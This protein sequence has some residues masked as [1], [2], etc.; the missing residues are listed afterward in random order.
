MKYCPNCGSGLNDN[1]DFCQQCGFKIRKKGSQHSGRKRRNIGSMNTQT[2]VLSAL[3]CVLI[4]GCV[5]VGI[6]LFS[7]MKGQKY[8]DQLSAANELLKSKEYQQAADTYEELTK[9][10]PESKDAYKGMA[11]AYS[12]LADQTK[13]EETAVKFR[14]KAVIGYEKVLEYD[15]SDE[16]VRKDIINQYSVLLAY[17]DNHGNAEKSQEIQKQLDKHREA[18]EKVSTEG[19]DSKSP[20]NSGD[21]PASNPEPNDH[22]NE[23]EDTVVSKKGAVAQ[24]EKR[25]ILLDY[26]NNTIVKAGPIHDPKRKEAE[27]KY[28]DLTGEEWYISDGVIGMDFADLDHDDQVEMIVYYTNSKLETLYDRDVRS[29]NLYADVYKV[30]DFNTV[31]RVVS[32]QLS[33]YMSGSNTSVEK[34]GIL[35]LDG[36]EYLYQ[37]EYV[38]GIFADGTTGYYT[39]Y[40]VDGDSFRR[41]YVLGQDQLGSAELQFVV[42]TYAGEEEHSTICCARDR[43]K[44]SD[45]LDDI[46]LCDG[47]LTFDYEN[48]YECD[49]L[50]WKQIGVNTN[51]PQD[52]VS[53]GADYWNSDA[54]RGGCAITIAA[55]YSDGMNASMYSETEIRAE[56]QPDINNTASPNNKAETEIEKAAEQETEQKTEQEVEQDK[57]LSGNNAYKEILDKLVEQYGNIDAFTNEDEFTSVYGVCY[58]DL[59]DINNDGKTEMIVICK[60]KEAE[61][62]ITNIYAIRDGKAECV[63]SSNELTSGSMMDETFNVVNTCDRGYMIFTQKGD[64]VSTIKKFYGF[65]KESGDFKVLRE[66]DVVEVNDGDGPGLSYSVDGKLISEANGFSE[67]LY[68]QDEQDT[69]EWL[70]Q[71]AFGPSF[72]L[73]FWR[74]TE[75]VSTDYLSMTIANTS[76]ILSN[77]NAYETFE[78]LLEHYRGQGT[79]VYNQELIDHE[80]HADIYSIGFGN[81]SRGCWV[82]ANIDSGEVIERDY[83]GNETILYLKEDE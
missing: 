79:H 67:E 83:D 70:G 8:R 35:S 37:Y 5:L 82:E 47:Y 60:E 33:Q 28:D 42:E 61:E 48:R 13:D 17:E 1:A 2:I 41:A 54:V 63:I 55:T 49:E 74:N 78:N 30:N 80:I 20:S 23:E 69:N 19:N 40:T 9:T 38:E 66:S 39:L 15:H 52:S 73:R 11:V 68:A 46:P 58:A 44:E 50:C 24:E 81:T 56:Y 34:A 4:V 65:D 59:L 10:N 7:N 51:V 25:S 75:Y 71:Y 6:S 26:Y 21:Q 14:R 3:I 72:T 22:E 53:Q 16:L 45:Y 27:L 57:S 29:S 64:E 36:R 62:Y 12:M 32:A 43:L 18:Y 77:E 31:D 76:A